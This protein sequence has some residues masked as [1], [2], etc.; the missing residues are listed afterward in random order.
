MIVNAVLYDL[1]GSKA[2]ASINFSRDTV[3]EDFHQRVVEIYYQLIQEDSARDF[4]ST[5]I[6]GSG[7]AISRISEVTLIIGVTDNDAVSDD[8]IERMKRFSEAVMKRVEQ[9]SVRE[10]KEEFTSLAE[11]LLRE[12]IRICF[13]TGEDPSFDDKSGSAVEMLFKTRGQRGRSYTVPAAIGPFGVEIMRISHDE[14]VKTDWSE[15]LSSADVFALIISP[16]LPTSD[17]V[18]QIVMRVRDESS[19]E[20]MIVPGSDDQLELAREYEEQYGL[21]L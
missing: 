14:I 5:N 10:F 4:V 3:S 12:R 7:T 20:L 21:E 16:P 17:R 9:S 2:L 19:S 1:L 18:E 15:N 11:A 8:D 6:D 13:I